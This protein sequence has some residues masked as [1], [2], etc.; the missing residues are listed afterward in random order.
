MTRKV[1]VL[2]I[3]ALFTMRAWSQTQKRLS[4]DEAL[5]TAV[6]RNLGVQLQRINLESSAIS[7]ELTRAAY[8][9]VVNSFA[10]HQTA[11]REATTRTEGESGDAFTRSSSDFNTTLSKPE[12]YG[13]TWNLNFNNNLFDSNEAF[14]LGETYTT[15]ISVGFSQELLQG[16]S[17]DK[18]VRR[19]TEYVAKVNYDGSRYDLETTVIL[20]LESTENAYW[21]LVLAIEQLK[22]QRQSLRLAQQ[23]YEQNKVKIEVG[24]LAPIELVNTE[25]TIATRESEIIDAE[26]RVFAAEDLLKKVLNLPREEW[27]YE[28]I[29]SDRATIT[30]VETDFDRDFDRAVT[31]RPELKKNLKEAEGALLS[32]KFRRNQLKPKLTLGGGYSST[33]TSAP[34]PISQETILPSSY[35]DAFHKA[36][37][38][39][40]PGW[41]VNL[42]LTWNPLNRQGKLNMAQAR[43][44]LRQKELIAEQTKIAIMEEVRTSRRDLDSNLKSIKANEKALRYR[45]ENLKAE[46]QKFQNGLST[47]YLVSEAQKDLAEA[48]SKVI[49]S[50]IQYLKS[51]VKYYK[52]MGLLPDQHK[53]LVH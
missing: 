14:S 28:I 39:E 50:K 41:Q 47:N 8:E 51:L 52:S 12:P 36:R 26:N 30:P 33:G 11:D 10:Q 37:F 53:I 5:R 18:E 49:E 22:V 1:I 20:V 21:D 27:F 15:T 13:L 19:N 2:T 31:N 34:I 48:E 24:T 6:E 29:P 32:F 7:L 46:V 25:A 9:P 45:E 42:N 3:L 16:F 43:V 38:N 4:L 35:N 40:F 17:L 44:G 23:L